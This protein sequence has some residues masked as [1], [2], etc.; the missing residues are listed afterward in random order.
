MKGSFVPRLKF[1]PIVCNGCIEKTQSL[2]DDALAAYDQRAIQVA[3]KLN[4]QS[5]KIVNVNVST[6]GSS[7]R[8]KQMSSRAMMADAESAPV[9]AAGDKTLTVRVSGTIE[10]Q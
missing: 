4:F 8:Y 6:S 10:L 3:K 2:I 1:L 9:F 5:Y 7:P